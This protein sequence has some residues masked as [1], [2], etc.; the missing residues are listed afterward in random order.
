MIAAPRRARR[1][2][3]VAYCFPPNGVVGSLRTLRVVKQLVAEGWTTTVLTGDVAS[4]PEGTRV[5][6]QLQRQ[7]PGEVREM[8]VWACRGLYTLTRLVK[9]LGIRRRKE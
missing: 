4:Y 5:D 3:V 6:R 2:L 1:A 7:V 9:K 8:R